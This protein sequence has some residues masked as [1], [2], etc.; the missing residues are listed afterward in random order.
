MLTDVETI[1]LHKSR[2]IIVVCVAFM[3]IYVMSTSRSRRIIREWDLEETNDMMRWSDSD[4]TLCFFT[5][6]CSHGDRV[7]TRQRWRVDYSSDDKDDKNGEDGDG[8][9]TDHFW[10]SADIKCV[11]GHLLKMFS[12][13]WGCVFELSSLCIHFGNTVNPNKPLS[14]TIRFYTSPEVTKVCL[15]FKA[16][17]DKVWWK[18]T[19]PINHN[20]K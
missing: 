6:S 13:L 16:E 7:G 11:S 12:V 4:L 17:S 15:S 18:Q 2:E 9:S 5:V 10:V 20:H 1:S 8:S 19:W 3:S 14:M